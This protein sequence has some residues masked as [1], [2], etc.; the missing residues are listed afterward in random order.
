MKMKSFKLIIMLLCAVQSLHALGSTFIEPPAETTSSTTSDVTC[1]DNESELETDDKLNPE[2]L[3]TLGAVNI[4]NLSG[5]GSD[6]EE[7]KRF[8]IQTL[9]NENMGILYLGDAQTEVRVGE[10]LTIEESDNI[11]F[12][13]NENF[14]GNAIFT[15]SSVTRS[16]AIDNT[17]ATVTIPVLAPTI[18][19]GACSEAP[20]TDDKVNPNLLNSLTAVNILNLSGKDCSGANIEKFKIITLPNVEHGILY[21]ADGVTAVTLNQVLTLEEANGLR[22]DP[23]DGCVGN[24]NFTYASIDRNNL[25]DETPATVT[26]PLVDVVAVTDIVTNPDR[27]IAEGNANPIIIDVLAND[28]G[29]LNGSRVHLVNTDG[30]LT[31]RIVV[32]GE[33]VWNVNDDNTVTFTPVAPFVGTPSSV[34]Y[35]V[36]DA[37]GASSNP[38]TISIAGQCVCSAYETSVPSISG[39]FLVILFLLIALIGSFLMRKE[40]FKLNS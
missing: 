3:N 35:L 24:A 8:L 36:E 4:L 9:P 13:P 11:R 27:G 15:Y 29:D 16:G 25:M 5:H 14:E 30:T 23:S 19:G 10:V 26:I 21:M 20:T 33:G 17:P 2:L 38:S 37:N 1:T 40:E 31:D 12:D 18:I 32:D 39:F 22:F 28:T 34:S 7:I 6:G